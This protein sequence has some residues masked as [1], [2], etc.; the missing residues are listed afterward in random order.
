[1]LTVGA[2]SVVVLVI[3]GVL[4][5]AGAVGDVHRARAAADLAA[6]AGAGTVS[7]GGCGL[8]ASLAAAN[9][10]VLTG[11]ASESDGSVIVAVAVARHWPGGWVGLPPSAF[12]RARAGLVDGGPPA[13]P[14][15]Q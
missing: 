7:G 8:A 9:G 4:A 1:V 15:S 10:A 6:L 14:G 2:I 12:A 13:E 11:C 3:T 5:V